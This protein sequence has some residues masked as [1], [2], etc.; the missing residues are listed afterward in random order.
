MG[1]CQWLAK[2]QRAAN[3]VSLSM[4]QTP[5][6]KDS[7]SLSLSHTHTHTYTHTHT[8]T[9]THTAGIHEALECHYCRPGYRWKNA[10]PCCVCMC[11]ITRGV[12]TQCFRLPF[13]FLFIS[14]GLSL[15]RLPNTTRT[16]PV[17][18]H[19]CILFVLFVCVYC[20]CMCELRWEVPAMPGNCV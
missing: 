20:F 8:H 5:S 15:S 16:G 13:N 6:T 19:L 9:H 7:E 18:P 2:P 1:P 3:L 4:P 14:V 12:H 11:V 10:T 17:C